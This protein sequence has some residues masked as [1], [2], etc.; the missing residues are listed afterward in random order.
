MSEPGNRCGARVVQP[1][2]VRPLKVKAEKP[3]SS[4]RRNVASENHGDKDIIKFDN[5]TA[6]RGCPK[7]E[8]CPGNTA[9]LKVSNKFRKTFFVEPE[10][11]LFM[12]KPLAGGMCDRKRRRRQGCFGS[13]GKN[14]TRSS[15]T[16]SSKTL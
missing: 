16:G 5:T 12:C 1:H 13:S 9:R 8:P 6:R 15:G 11:F 4:P 2:T 7:I 14:A 3:E 10:H